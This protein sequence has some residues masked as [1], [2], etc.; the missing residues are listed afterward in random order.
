[1]ITTLGNQRPPY[2]RAIGIP[3]S[4]LLRMK[5]KDSNVPANTSSRATQMP[6]LINVG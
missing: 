1:M 6:I 2:S 3:I 4:M 5:P